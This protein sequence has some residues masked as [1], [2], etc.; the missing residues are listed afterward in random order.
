MKLSAVYQTFIDNYSENTIP[1]NL[2]CLIV[3]VVWYSGPHWYR[4]SYYVFMLCYRNED[5]DRPVAP[6]SGTSFVR[7]KALKRRGFTGRLT[8]NKFLKQSLDLQTRTTQLER[9]KLQLEVRKVNALEA[10]ASN[11]GSIRAILSVV[12]NVEFIQCPEQ[13]E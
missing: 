8:Q 13:E 1:I 5:N 6:V 7:P 11:L 9:K 12:H 4:K 2:W 10:I 3:Q